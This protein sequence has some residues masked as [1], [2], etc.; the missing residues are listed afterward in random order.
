MSEGIVIIIASVR[1]PVELG[2]WVEHVARQ[3]VPP[4]QLIWAITSDDDLPP[5]Y[6]GPNPP[7]DVTIVRCPVGL[8]KQR[9]RGLAAIA[10]DPAFVAFFD[11]DYVPTAT[12]LADIVRSFAA[13]PDAV[14]LTGDMIADGINSSGIPYEE[15]VELVAAHER[16]PPLPA[17]QIALEPW[18]A[19]Y[20]CNMVFRAGV[21]A[22]EQFD[23]RLPLYGWQED[24]DFA[25]RVA[26]GRPIGRTLGFAGVHQGVKGGRGSGKRL[27]YSQIANPLYLLRKGSMKRRK[28]LVMASKN[29]IAN[30]VR[31]L[32]PEPWIDRRGRAIGN[33]L[34]IRD[35]LLGRIDPM[36]VL[37]L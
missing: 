7:A 36:R 34:A 6:R 29:M 14:G 32:R 15:A 35:A 24:L 8:T 26:R 4:T 27:G 10:G 28:A 25:A 22:G 3:T 21:I 11:D 13:L 19:L 1:R 16:K 33:W 12:C 23:E 37:D 18:D 5:A 20:G 17:D 31:S 2:R 9:N 30:H